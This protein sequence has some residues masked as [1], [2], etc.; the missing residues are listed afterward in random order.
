MQSFS[1]RPISLQI[2]F[3]RLEQQVTLRQSYHSSSWQPLELLNPGDLSTNVNFF[4]YSF[5]YSFPHELGTFFL[6]TLWEWRIIGFWSGWLSPVY[7]PLFLTSAHIVILIWALIYKWGSFI[8]NI[9][10]NIISISSFWY[11]IN[12]L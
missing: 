6:V 4:F 2:T 10:P 9:T 11:P 3:C 1:T 7:F 12:K 5:D 8:W